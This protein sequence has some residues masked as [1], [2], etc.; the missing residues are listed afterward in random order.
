MR[1]RKITYSILGAL[2]IFTIFTWLYIFEMNKNYLEVFFFDVGEGDAILFKKGLS[3]ILVDGGPDKKILEK[4][5][6][7][8][9]FFDKEI[10]V[11]IST[12]PDADHLTG[13]IY[14]LK[15]FKV[16]NIIESGAEKQGYFFKE[17][18]NLLNNSKGVKTFKARS[19]DKFVFG[20]VLADILSPE[21]FL[22]ENVKNTN[23]ASIVAKIFYGKNSF[24]MTGDASAAV[25]ENLISKN[26]N[27]KGNILKIGHHG[28]KTASSDEFIKIV[29]PEFAVISVGRNNKYGH[30]ATE[31]LERLKSFKILRTDEKGDIKFISSGE[32][33]ILKK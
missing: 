25:E 16:K 8:L 22:V 30:P 2:A 20:G 12:H 3:E 4:L 9:P 31:V 18:K 26:F 33:I 15:S 7:A 28:A 24:I 5:G 17:W 32:N 1:G 6:K 10:E 19:G 21:G 29:N 23:D 14:V 27:L 11:I 13:L